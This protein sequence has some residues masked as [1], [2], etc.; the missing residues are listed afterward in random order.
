[1]VEVSLAA[2]ASPSTVSSP[3]VAPESPPKTWLRASE[4][5]SAKPTLS[6]KAT[7]TLRSSG[8]WVPEE[9]WT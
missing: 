2:A 8:Y 1:M 4:R 7:R 6:P 5:V 9:D 3:V